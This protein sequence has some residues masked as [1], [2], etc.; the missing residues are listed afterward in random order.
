MSKEIKH[1]PVL[2][3]N[4]P[5]AS[6]T[7]IPR[8]SI[9]RAVAEFNKRI[10]KRGAQ[11]GELVISYGRRRGETVEQY[12]QRILTINLHEVA[13]K[14]NQ[15]RVNDDDTLVADIEFLEGTPGAAALQKVP[16]TSFS[17][18][19]SSAKP[20]TNVALRRFVDYAGNM[21]I[22][23]LDVVMNESKLTITSNK[24][25]NEK[26]KHMDA[27]RQVCT[28]GPAVLNGIAPTQALLNQF[29][30]YKLIGK[31][32]PVPSD[33]G[34]AQFLKHFVQNHQNS[35]AQS[36]PK[37][38]VDAKSEPEQHPLY[39]NLTTI[40]KMDVLQHFPGVKLLSM[41]PARFRK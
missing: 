14:T 11:F 3:T 30:I 37:E 5:S 4:T 28:S 13:I 19:S 26:E 25:S 22:V 24:N 31:R 35:K 32:V 39:V 41:I 34:A 21:S 6:G 9:E 7:V 17:I 1:V 27:I 10:E 20:R 18:R 12:Q 16:G 38:S 29:V 8:E 36:A 2:F 15:L 33:L 23:T 40:E